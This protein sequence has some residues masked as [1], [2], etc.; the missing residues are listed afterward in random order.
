MGKPT[1]VPIIVGNLDHLLLI[2]IHQITS[3]H[4]HA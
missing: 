2:D 4:T 3:E 1:I